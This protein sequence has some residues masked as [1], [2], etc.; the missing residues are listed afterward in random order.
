MQTRFIIVAIAALVII[1][2]GA[3]IG[4]GWLWWGSGAGATEYHDS[5]AD[6][7][8][9]DARE[10]AMGRTDDAGADLGGAIDRASRAGEDV[11]GSARRIEA[12]YRDLDQ[13][14]R[15]VAAG[16]VG[17]AE[18]AGQLADIT[19]AGAHPLDGGAVGAGGPA[20]PSEEPAG[21]GSAPGG[22]TGAIEPP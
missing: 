21:H 1:S 18:L 9:G 5:N 13:R 3:G 20:G 11:A 7:R 14:V 4:V 8:L 17:D 22:S 10:D 16:I 19:R 6:E 15:G 2:A 12:E